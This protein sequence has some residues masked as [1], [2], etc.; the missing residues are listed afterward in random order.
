MGAALRAQGASVVIAL[1]RVQGYEG[2]AQEYDL[3]AMYFD[4]ADVPVDLWASWD[5]TQFVA[6]AI[7]ADRRLIERTQA[8]VVI[9]D[10]RF[11]VPVAASECGIPSVML[12]QSAHLVGHVFQGQSIP[13]H[14]WRAPVEAFNEYLADTYRL[15]SGDARELYLRSKILMVS[16]PEMDP[17]PGGFP[18]D[19]IRYVGPI[20]PLSLSGLGGRQDS[21]SRIENGSNNDTKSPILMYRVVKTA[22]D[23]LGVR[24]HFDDIGSEVVIATGSQ[25]LTD[26]I[27]PHMKGWGGRVETFSAVRSM[28]SSLEIVVH[29]AGHG[30]AL[31]TLQA[32][33]LSL[34]LA[35]SNPERFENAVHLQKL[36][37]A[38]LVRPRAL[39][40]SSG[41]VLSMEHEN[42][43]DWSQA[44]SLLDQLR[45]ST[46]MR[47][48][49]REVQAA[50]GKYSVVDA[51]EAVF[52]V[53]G[54]HPAA[55]V[56]E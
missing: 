6:S 3:P 14:V 21:L 45:A 32:G 1:T 7:A 46:Q 26:S 20:T 34:V 24:E 10:G 38:G 56:S 11:S 13:G 12:A 28:A 9:Y 27:R 33:A 52:E 49:S 8:D 22:A 35:D 5:N 4:D 19:H 17:L 2:V 29:L 48:R 50:L 30:M 25:R 16:I 54:W 37:V 43:S 15:A 51:V 42:E 53:S 18:A 55:K 31:S 47:S 36:G 39:A 44:R 41:S 23:A 40:E